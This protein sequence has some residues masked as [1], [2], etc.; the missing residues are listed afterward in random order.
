M[1]IGPGAKTVVSTNAYTHFGLL[2][3]W[4]DMFSLGNLGQHD[5]GAPVMSDMYGS[6]GG[7]G[8][9]EIPA[10]SNRAISTESFVPQQSGTVPINFNSSL[11]FASVSSEHFSPTAPSTGVQ[12][13]PVISCGTQSLPAT[14]SL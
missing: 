3:T 12:L 4:Q 2:A 1:F 5:V 11:A 7:G 13:L 10:W 9:T 14:T 8:T 6:G